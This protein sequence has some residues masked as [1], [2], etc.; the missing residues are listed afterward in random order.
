MKTY[1]H[2]LTKK[3]HNIFLL[4]AACMPMT[5]AEFTGIIQEIPDDV[6]EM[7][8]G[9]SWIPNCPVPLENLR[10]ITVTHWGYDGQEHTGHIVV[11]AQIAEEIVAIFQELYEAHFPIERMEIVDVYDA[12]DGRSMEANNSSAFCCRENTTFPGTFSLHSYGLALDINPLV[13]PYVRGELVLP[14][15]GRDYLD[16]SQEYMGGVTKSDDNACYRIFTKYGYEWG[17]DFIGRID[18][19]HFHKPHTILK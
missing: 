11:H 4:A 3:T 19:Q 1:W 17:G 18:Y 8:I 10:Y 14:A 7:M 2:F 9:R 16:R 6:R 12:D 5:H 13:N 15:G